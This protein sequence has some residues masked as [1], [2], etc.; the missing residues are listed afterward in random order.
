MS[1]FYIIIL[2]F[3]VYDGKTAGH[4]VLDMLSEFANWQ[5]ELARHVKPHGQPLLS[6]RNSLSYFLST[7]PDRQPGLGAKMGTVA[8]YTRRLKFSL[9]HWTKT[10]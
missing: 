1:Q 4:N 10:I 9:C 3:E 2:R 7:G 6:V 8:K 5:T